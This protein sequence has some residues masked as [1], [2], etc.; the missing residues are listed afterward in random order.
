MRFRLVLTAATLVAGM[1]V[2]TAFAQA[3]DGPKI[4][5]EKYKPSVGQSGKDVIWVPTND[6]VAEAMLKMAD[7]KPGDLV[8]DLGSG[9]GK[10]AIAAAKNFGA[11]AVGIEYNKDMAELAT[12]NAARAGVSDKV[13]IINGDIFVED[14]SKANVLTM[15]LLPDLN[16]KLRPTILKMTPGTR[17]V[18]NSFHMGDWEPDALI[19]N[20]YTQG[21]YWVVPGNAAGKWTIKGIEGSKAATL[22]MTQRYQRV[23]GTLSIDGKAQPILGANLTG[24][25]LKFSFV[26]QS[27][28]SRIV[29]VTL[30]GNTFAGNVVENSPL[31]EV[32]GV[33]N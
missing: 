27:G 10:I 14:F 1:S 12:R 20:G 2:A 21:Y 22:D 26:D 16:L 4:G 13:K 15:Y 3:T 6:A 29:D 23:G 5:D 9:D 25:R 11:T 32:T 28:Q 8:Y 24:N 19:G 30:K 33:R 18:T 31:Y 7:V 17:V